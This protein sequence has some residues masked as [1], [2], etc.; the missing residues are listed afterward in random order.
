[1]V[2]SEK[3][4]FAQRLNL[5]LDGIDFPGK[6]AGRQTR[7]AGMVSRRKR[8]S[9][10]GVRKWLEGYA[11]PGL[12]YQVIL[13]ELTGARR[14]W[15]A[16]GT[17]AMIQD[18]A[19]YQ[20]TELPDSSLGESNEIDDQSGI[21]HLGNAASIRRDVDSIPDPVLK[22]KAELLVRRIADGSISAD[23]LDAVLRLLL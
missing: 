22:Q 3:E 16:Y 13:C 4:A 5:A 2:T 19:G 7:L 12:D 14:E 9:Q 21:Y 20:W 6:G 17:G 23:K 18:D 11:I 10:K 8:V 15:L 1:M